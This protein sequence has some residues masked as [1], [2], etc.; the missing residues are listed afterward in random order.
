MISRKLYSDE[1]K[2]CKKEAEK[3]VRGKE[4][5]YKDDAGYIF[6]LVVNKGVPG[7]YNKRG[8]K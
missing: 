2:Y 1:G 8:K 3:N 5:V 4:E 7:S 6:R